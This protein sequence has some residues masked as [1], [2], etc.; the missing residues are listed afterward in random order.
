MEINIT[1]IIQMI[2]F[3]I[4]YLI[5][6]RLFLRSACVYIAQEDLHKQQLEQQ[7]LNQQEHVTALTQQ[8]EQD[9]VI[10]QKRLSSE[11]PTPQ[12]RSG[13]PEKSE[14][15]PSPVTPSSHEI[16]TLTTSLTHAI[17]KKVHHDD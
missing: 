5:I 6:D 17:V 14:Q 9:W 13:A 10:L 2:H 15:I 12:H 8:N 3:G 11:S 1:L 7:A 16:Q 4:A